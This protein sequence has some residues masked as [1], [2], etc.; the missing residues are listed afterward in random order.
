MAE[1]LVWTGADG[2][3]IDLTDE[4]AGFSALANGTRGLRSV[5]YAFTT[6]QFAGMDGDF[7]QSVR[8][9]ANKPTLGLLLQ[10]RNEGE[11][12]ARARALIRSMR[13]KSGPGTLTHVDDDGKRRELTCF[14]TNGLEGDEAVET[15]LPGAWWKMALQFY[16]PDPWWYG[17][18]VDLGYVMGPP[19]NWFP[20]FPLRFFRDQ[21]GG[22]TPIE[23][24]G[25]ED[26]YPTWTVTGP[27]SGLTLTNEST[28]R[29]I[30]LSTVL[31]A[32]QSL[33]IDTRPF[34]QSVI[35][36]DGVNLFGDLA[37]D[38]A[39]WALAPGTNLVTVSLSGATQ[40]SR[41][42]ATYRPRYPG[43]T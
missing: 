32:G 39:L 9:E 17:D 18:P 36:N 6:E 35:R 4:S 13:P 8:A 22:S 15:T 24:T 33:T 12:R 14:V 30:S 1:R 28:G 34:Y 26:A 20:L 38:P 25:D 5:T 40:A 19:P 42:A 11:F 3:T 21:L 2:S 41:V 31:L 7:V 27:G 23:N 43:I 37:S 29:S 16:A 10:A